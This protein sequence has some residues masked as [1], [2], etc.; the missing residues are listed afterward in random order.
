MILN[1]S[2][3][4]NIARMFSAL[5]SDIRIHNFKTKFIKVHR[6]I[7]RSFLSLKKK[8][9]KSLWLKLSSTFFGIQV[10]R[11]WPNPDMRRHNEGYAKESVHKRANILL[12]SNWNTYLVNSGLTVSFSAQVIMQKSIKISTHCFLIGGHS[13]WDALWDEPNLSLTTTGILVRERSY[14]RNGNSLTASMMSEAVMLKQQIFLS[15]LLL[16]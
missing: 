11:A 13:N 14:H 9:K 5:S 8:V 15:P 2:C 3:N 10:S 6:K 16:P 12:K 7:S 1:V 4:K